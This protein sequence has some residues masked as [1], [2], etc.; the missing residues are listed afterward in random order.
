MADPKGK[1][2][3][4][5]AFGG[6]AGVALI[7]ALL[8][9]KPGAAAPEDTKWDYLLQCQATLAALIGETN[10]NLVGIDSKLY[11]L[12]TLNAKVDSII[13]SLNTIATQLGAEPVEALTPI[14]SYIDAPP[15][16]IPVGNIPTELL[17]Y[18]EKGAIFVLHMVSDSRFITY[19]IR[20]DRNATWK[21][22]IDDLVNNSIET[23]HELG[24]WIE[25]ATGGVF[26]VTVAAKDLEYREDYRLTATNNSAAVITVNK[27]FGVKKGY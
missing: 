1:E 20:Y 27:I 10:S 12:A 25:T 16:Q 15:V 11:G 14:Y 9:A 18:Y 19:N 22:N 23:P 7:S 8:K 21:I 5:G 2:V 24:A 17:Q 6:A 4:L 13:T 26:A 3:A